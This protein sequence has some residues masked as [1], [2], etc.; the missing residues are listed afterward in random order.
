ML[1]SLFQCQ[2]SILLLVYNMHIKTLV[3]MQQ[4][5]HVVIKTHGHICPQILAALAIT[6]WAFESLPE[7]CKLIQNAAQSPQ[8]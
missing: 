3:A 8:I 7:C 5:I 2:P 4:D 1:C 6:H